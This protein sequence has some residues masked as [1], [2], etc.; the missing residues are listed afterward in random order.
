MNLAYASPE[1]YALPLTTIDAEASTLAAYRGKTLLIVNTASKCG[2]TPQ[3]EGLQKLSETYAKR[4]LVVLGFPSNDFGGQEPGA[5]AEIKSFCTTR[6]KVGFP[7]FAKAPVKG[8][9]AQP[10]FKFL[11]EHAPTPG[12]VKWNFEKFLV[13]GD[14]RV[15]ARFDSGVKPGDAKIAAAIESALPK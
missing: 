5:N 14:G 2:Y 6:F 9:D 11:T 3:Y 15:V 8:P 13:A 1:F 12:P 4:G 10:V 7:M